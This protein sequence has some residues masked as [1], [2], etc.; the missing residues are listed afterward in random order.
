[1]ITVT[2]DTI[3][4]IR[5]TI[6]GNAHIGSGNP[7]LGSFASSTRFDSFVLTFSARNAHTRSRV[8]FPH[9]ILLGRSIDPSPLLF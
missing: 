3:G 8:L 1:M 5:G 4:T 2:V 6:R 9:S 7:S